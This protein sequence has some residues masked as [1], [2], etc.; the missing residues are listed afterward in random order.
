LTN[1][2]EIGNISIIDWVT[3]GIPNFSVVCLGEEICYR[4][5]N[6]YANL[7]LF[8]KSLEHDHPGCKLK[9]QEMWTSSS[10]FLKSMGHI[11]GNQADMRGYG[12]NARKTLGVKGGFDPVS[13]FGGALVAR[14][15]GA[16]YVSMA[17]AFRHK[18]GKGRSTAMIEFGLVG[19]RPG[20]GPK[21]GESVRRDTREVY[22]VLVT[23]DTPIPQRLDDLRLRN[24]TGNHQVLVWNWQKD[25][26]SR[27]HLDIKNTFSMMGL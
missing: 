23:S 20:S 6:K 2:R 5:L 18:D 11:Y 12:H 15:L 21:S 3:G 13:H 26:V 1:N 7:D 14:K 19:E 9:P 16:K 27:N 25:E 4:M 8:L 22:F 24:I 10:E 17:D